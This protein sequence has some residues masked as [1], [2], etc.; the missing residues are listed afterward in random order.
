MCSFAIFWNLFSSF[1]L[2]WLLKLAYTKISQSNL[3][4]LLLDPKHTQQ[5]IN[6]RLLPF[7]S[8][9]VFTVGEPSCVRQGWNWWIPHPEIVI[10]P[11][12]PN[13]LQH[14]CGM[15]VNTMLLRTLSN[16]HTILKITVYLG[17][18]CSKY[19]VQP[20]SNT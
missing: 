14:P 20:F 15:E 16:Q 4:L 17:W 1:L 5:Q 6:P 13:Q 3:D 10:S 7:F 11:K 12:Y 18:H 19:Y 2:F 8:W 9:Q